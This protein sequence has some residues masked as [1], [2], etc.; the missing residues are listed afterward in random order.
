MQMVTFRLADSLPGSV[1]ETI[2]AS[3]K[4]DEDRFKRL[5]GLIDRGRGACILKR[6]DIAAIVE[7]ALQHFDGER[8]RL[9]AWVL[10]PNHVHVLIEQSEGYSLSD[11]LHSWKSFTSKKINMLEGTTGAVW[12]SDY[13]DR[14]VR[15]AE[16][17]ENALRYIEQNPVKAGLVSHA[18]EWLF[19]SA[20]KKRRNAGGTPAVPAKPSYS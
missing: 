12:A 13:H 6:E 11:I 19:S 1:Y 18:E 14:F 17:Y 8:Y 4:T 16:H 15:N 5:D 9:L 2:L 7:G 3:A 10:M 20:Y